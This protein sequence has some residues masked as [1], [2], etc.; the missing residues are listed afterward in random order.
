MHLSRRVKSRAAGETAL[1]R[2]RFVDAMLLC[3]AA[4]ASGSSI[5]FR[6]RSLLQRFAVSS[7]TIL[8]WKKF[9]RVK[10]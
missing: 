9:T 3:V 1:K 10:V 6:L 8:V 4:V 5:I 7:S 2:H